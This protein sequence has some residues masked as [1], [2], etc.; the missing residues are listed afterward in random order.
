MMK[1]EIDKNGWANLDV[2]G[3]VSEVTVDVCTLIAQILKELNDEGKRTFVMGIV[4][5]LCAD[6]DAKEIEYKNKEDDNDGRE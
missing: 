1:Y 2:E 5:F 3:A 4:D 6:D